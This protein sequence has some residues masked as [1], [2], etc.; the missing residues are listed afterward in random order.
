MF[1]GT[2]IYETADACALPPLLGTGAQLQ[3]VHANQFKCRCWVRDTESSH[4]FTFPVHHDVSRLHEEIMA[5]VRGRCR[6]GK[7]AASEYVTVMCKSNEVSY[8]Q[9]LRHDAAIRPLNR[10]VVARRSLSH[11]M[12][13]LIYPQ[14]Q[15]TV[16][17]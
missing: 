17:D 9:V 12:S 3:A 8:L 15:Q 7:D 1:I 10:S 11:I 2:Y 16:T 6:V 4:G 14:S 13:V 5:A